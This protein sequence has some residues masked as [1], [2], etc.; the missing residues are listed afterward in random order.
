MKVNWPD[1]LHI[2]KLKIDDKEP[3]RLEQESFLKAVA[4]KRLRPEV[5]AE[6]GLAAMQCADMILASVKEHKWD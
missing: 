3:L 6:D 1:L 2:E 5:S 4:D